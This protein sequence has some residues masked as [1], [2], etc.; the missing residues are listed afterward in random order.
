M[1]I[2]PLTAGCRSPYRKSPVCRDI[3]A[4][5]KERI[6]HIAIAVPQTVALRRQLRQ[7]QTRL[8][9]VPP[10]TG[11]Q[12]PPKQAINQLPYCSLAAAAVRRV[13]Y[14]S[15]FTHPADDTDTVRRMRLGRDY[16][17]L[18]NAVLDGRFTK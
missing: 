17:A 3:A 16:Q 14:C 7:L 15:N 12:R 10:A 5:E 8:I 9:L 6:D 2:A 4:G 1:G 18:P 11:W 13:V